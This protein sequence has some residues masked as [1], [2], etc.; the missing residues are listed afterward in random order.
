MRLMALVLAAGLLWPAST[1]A[2]DDRSSSSAYMTGNKLY[3]QCNSQDYS[4]CFG[5]VMGSFRHAE[6]DE[7]E[8]ILRTPHHQS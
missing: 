3:E 1:F 2:Q 6:R 5:Y 8:L 4:L 7:T